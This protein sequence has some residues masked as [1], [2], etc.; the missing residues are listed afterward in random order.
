[1]AAPCICSSASA[2]SASAKRPSIGLG[3][4]AWLETGL[5]LWDKSGAGQLSAADGL[6]PFAVAFPCP[7]PPSL[8]WDKRR[9]AVVY[10]GPTKASPPGGLIGRRVSKARDG[11]ARVAEAARLPDPLKIGNDGD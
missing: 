5:N 11:D 9:V 8:I 1:M 2:L 7:S 3:L 6:G 10:S 4:A